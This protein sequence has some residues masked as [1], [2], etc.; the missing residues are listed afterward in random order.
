MKIIKNLT[1]NSWTYG[2]LFPPL[3]MTVW[4]WVKIRIDGPNKMMGI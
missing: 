3:R 4:V 2:G 1:L